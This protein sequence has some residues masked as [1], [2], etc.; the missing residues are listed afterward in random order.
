MLCTSVCVIIAIQKLMAL[1]CVEIFFR[2]PIPKKLIVNT[3]IFSGGTVTAKE[4]APLRTR[5]QG[6]SSERDKSIAGKCVFAG[7][8]SPLPASSP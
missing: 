2:I 1:A 4:P 3:S 5:G 6:R 7:G 8:C